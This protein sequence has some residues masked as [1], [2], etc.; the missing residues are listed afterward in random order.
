MREGCMAL[1]VLFFNLECR[2]LQKMSRWDCGGVL[3]E[4]RA[5][6]ETVEIKNGYNERNQKRNVT[7]NLFSI[8]A[9]GIKQT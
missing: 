1:Y 4:T 5:E 3:N 8:L 2:N 7:M 6:L 9:S